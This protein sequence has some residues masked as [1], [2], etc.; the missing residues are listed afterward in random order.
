VEDL[1]AQNHQA[2]ERF[3]HPDIHGVEPRLDPALNRLIEER[4]RAMDRSKGVI[5]DGYPASKEQGDHLA[6]LVTEFQFAPPIV[7]QLGLSDA[8]A[9]R[10]A[11]K[12]DGRDMEQDLKDYH[13]ELDFA[14][15]YFSG[16]RI[17]EIDASKPVAQVA[18]QIR[19][20]LASK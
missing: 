4:L 10:R 2:F 19:E 6:L 12:N 18:K 16:T 13:R 14:R 11:R 8:E 3:S 9:R 15:V 17:H 5:L 20:V 1:I 7:L